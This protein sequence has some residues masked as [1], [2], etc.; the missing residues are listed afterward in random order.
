MKDARELFQWKENQKALAIRLWIALDDEDRTAQLAALLESLSSFM[1][2]TYG[3]AV[4]TSG[5]IHFLAVLGIDPEM[6]RLRNA[7][8]YS[9]I[10]AGMVYCVRVLGV[11]KL[12]PA[13]QRDEQSDEDRENFLSMRRRYLADGTYSPMSEM[14][15]LLAYSKYIGMNEG[16]S[17]NAYW[18][19]DKKIFYLNG[20]P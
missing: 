3:N 16:N 15:S 19:E 17:G 9:Y 18:S 11:E 14:L 5:L 6:N 4:F 7:R 12:L 1:F 13:A 2:S 8:N 10:L 20:R